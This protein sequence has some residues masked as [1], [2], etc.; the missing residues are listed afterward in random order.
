MV[1][2]IIIFIFF[3]STMCKTKLVTPLVCAISFWHLLSRA[4]LVGHR[5]DEM[6]TLSREYDHR[7]NRHITW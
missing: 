3:Y 1:V 4:T 5:I 6:V 7:L 2:Y